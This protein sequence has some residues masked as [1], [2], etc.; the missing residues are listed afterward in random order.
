MLQIRSIAA[1]GEIQVFLVVFTS[2]GRQNKGT[3]TQVSEANAVLREL[4][5]SVLA[6][7]E[8]SNIAKLS[9]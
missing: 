7:W 5:C 9:L 8:L 1:D 3:G 2:D 4:Y 6:K